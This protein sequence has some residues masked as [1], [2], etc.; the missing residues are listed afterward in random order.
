[1]QKRLLTWILAV[2]M[3]AVSVCCVACTEKP[4]VTTLENLELPKLSQ[5]EMVVVEKVGDKEYKY[6]VIPLNGTE[7]EGL[8]EKS[9]LLDVLEFIQKEFDVT[10]ELSYGFINKF[11]QLPSPGATNEYVY[12]YTSVE[13]DFDTSAWATTFDCDGT[14]V[15]TSAVGCAEMSVQKGCVIYIATI[16]YNG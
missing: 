4:S 10:L 13:K 12:L 1:M 15:C 2:V 3:I 14:K 7:E 6:F 8:S 16:V 5:N 9:T 11:D